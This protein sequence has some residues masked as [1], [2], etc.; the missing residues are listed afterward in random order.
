MSA[1]KGVY[2]H[3]RLQVALTLMRS[4]LYKAPKALPVI[5]ACNCRVLYHSCNS[6]SIF[7]TIFCIIL[8][9]CVSP[10]K[11]IIFRNIFVSFHVIFSVWK[12]PLLSIFLEILPAVWSGHCKIQFCDLHM[13]THA[14]ASPTHCSETAFC[15]LY[16]Y[17]PCRCITT[18]CPKTAFCDL[19]MYIPCR[20]ITTP[21]PKTAFC[22]LYMYIPCRCI[23]NPL[24][25]NC[26]LWPAHVHT[27][28]CIT[29]PLSKNC[30]LWPVHVH[31]MQ[32][33]HNPLSKSA[34]CDLY[35]YTHADI[36]PT[37]CPKTAFQHCTG[38]I[39]TGSWKGRGNQY[40]QFARVLYCKLPTNGKQLPAFPLEAMTGI[41]PRPQRLEARV[42]PDCYT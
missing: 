26:I 29:N 17:I 37:P 36:S 42:L 15:D 40:I 21:C 2:A 35:M 27:C 20:C 5:T 18:P 33:H 14:D 6:S 41:E 16:M 39:T 24:S 31:P 32:M 22:D 19:Y 11:L 8:C 28:R 1:Y 4:I 38:H 23:T 9:L 34:F 12:V 7:K 10:L 3:I 30:I 13:Y 25:K